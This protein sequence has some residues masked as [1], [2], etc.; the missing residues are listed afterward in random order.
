MGIV[1]FP[2]KAVV[3]LP[4]TDW[5]RILELSM[6]TAQEEVQRWFWCDATN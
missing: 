4:A 5:R 3:S 2:G 1:R 6:D